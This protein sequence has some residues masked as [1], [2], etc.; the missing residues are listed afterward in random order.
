MEREGTQK[1][2]L[3]LGDLLTERDFELARVEGQRCRFKRA[4]QQT[5]QQ[6]QALKFKKE[7][8]EKRKLIYKS[9]ILHLSQLYDILKAEM[10]KLRR[11][12][13]ELKAICLKAQEKR[14]VMEKKLKEMEHFKSKVRRAVE[15]CSVKN[16]DFREELKKVLDELD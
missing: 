7:A 10:E 16:S 3:Q 2:I 12:R 11:E 5:L 4:F 6:V 14:Q 13:D 1:Q 9:M 8:L 15:E